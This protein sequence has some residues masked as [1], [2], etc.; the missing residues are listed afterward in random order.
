VAAGCTQVRRTAP[1]RTANE[2]LLLSTAA[3]NAAER[4]D[5]GLSDGTAVYLDARR[6]DSYDRGY[7]VGAIRRAVLTQG[8]RLV[9]DRARAEVVIEVRSGALSTNRREFLVGIPSI[10]VPVPTTEAL[11][12]PELALVKEFDR[13]GVAKFAA[14]VVDA[15][16]GR[17][18]R[19]VGPV[20]G[21]SWI[22]HG[23]VF[24]LSFSERNVLPADV[25]V[26][27]PEDGTHGDGADTP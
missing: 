16:S 1:E 11:T 24:G 15:G 14:V 21:L 23:S 17:L 22:D 7:A 2:Q 25:P 5:F 19:T 27:P 18:R 26:N 13:T 3:D 6:F 4:M 9:R 8:G 10:D 20:Y 12:L